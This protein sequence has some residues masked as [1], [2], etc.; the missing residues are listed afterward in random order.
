MRAEVPWRLLFAHLRRSWFRTALTAAGVALAIFLLVLL[1]TVVTELQSGVK[2]AARSRLIVSSAVSLFVNLPVRM[3]R[4]LRNVPG[5]REVTHWTWFGGVY[6]DE[7]NMFARFAVDA[8]SLRR[9]YG[10]LSPK[11]EIRLSTAEWEAFEEDRTGCI[12]GRALLSRFQDAEGKPIFSL[13]SVI[14]IQGDIYPGEYRFTVRGIY[15]SLNPNFDEQTMFFHWS[16][17]DETTGRR[18]EVSTFTL[19]LKDPEQAPEVARAVDDMFRSSATRTRTLTEQAFNLQF[20]GMW[21]N[22]PVFL[23][24]I[25]GAV[26]FAAFMVTLNTLLLNAR[27]R[28]GEVA[29]LKTLGFPDG[30]VGAMNLVEALVLCVFG[31]GLG[32]GLAWFLFNVSPVGRGMDYFV[33]DAAEE[34]G[35]NQHDYDL[36]K[37]I[38]GHVDSTTSV[39][40]P[41]ASNAAVFAPSEWGQLMKSSR[42][43]RLQVFERDFRNG[44]APGGLDYGGYLTRLRIGAAGRVEREPLSDAAG[45]FPQHDWRRTTRRHRYSYLAARRDE[46][47]APNAVVRCDL[48]TGQERS[49]VLPLGQAVSEPIFVPR[50]S[51]AREDEGWLLAVAYDPGEHRSR[52]LVLDASEREGLKRSAGILREALHSL[53]LV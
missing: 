36:L 31:G 53:S 40:S 51:D 8:P 46:S 4:E 47:V 2:Y 27:E 28:I 7:K 39:S 32:T 19:L 44:E 43:G 41:A 6:I 38:Y 21:G 13:G 37:T 11:E 14:P 20:Q 45:E 26:L 50:T 18:G 29:V 30:S 12:V 10:D 16:Y 49:H 23:S 34:V 42:G 52:L 15:E 9:V 3:E 48:E 33:P 24:F 1:R 5:V 35:P 22:I 17:V 25:G